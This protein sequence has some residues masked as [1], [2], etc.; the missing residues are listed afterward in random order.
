[1]Q[2]P[3]ASATADAAAPTDTDTEPLHTG[4]LDVK[5]GGEVHT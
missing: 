2:D 5:K 3:V 4:S 1:M